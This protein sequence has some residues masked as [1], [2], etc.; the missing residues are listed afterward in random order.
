M[1]YKT[2]C[3]ETHLTNQCEALVSN[4][5]K[6][7]MFKDFASLQEIVSQMNVSPQVLNKHKTL[8]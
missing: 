6:T 4:K 5:H 8:C 2:L 3:L 7:L 1:Q